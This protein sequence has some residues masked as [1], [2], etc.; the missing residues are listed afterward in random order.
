MQRYTIVIEL[1]PPFYSEWMSE[2]MFPSQRPAV[3]IDNVN[4][5]YSRD[6]IHWFDMEHDHL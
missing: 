5:K 1:S 2:E 3:V 4:G 6:G